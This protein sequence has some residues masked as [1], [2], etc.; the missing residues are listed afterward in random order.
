MPL[1]SLLQC[2]PS[3]VAGLTGWPWT[4]ET[5]TEI[6]ASRHDWPRISIVTPSYNQAA[7]LEETIRSVLLQNYPN[8]QYI[9]ID[10]GSTDGSREVIARYA[11]WLD[12]W[13]SERDRGQSHAI[14]KGLSRCN[15]TWFNWIN[16]D[17]CL[18]PGALAAVAAAHRP[19]ALLI[20]GFEVA[21]PT[22]ATSVPLGRTKTGPTV[23]DALVNHFICQQGMFFR[24]DAVKARHGVREDLHYVMDLELFADLLLQGG[25]EAVSVTSAHLAF[26]RR[27]VAAKTTLAPEKFFAEEHRL[28][29]GLGRAA[30]IDATLL[31]HL[32]AS[33]PIEIPKTATARI[34]P[35]RLA[36]LLAK[37]YWWDG[38]IETA[39]RQRQLGEFRREA[40]AFAQSFPQVT[41][42]RIS[43]LH[44]L[45]RLPEPLLRF[46]SQFR[47][48]PQP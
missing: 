16:S 32:H 28:F 36:R 27:H 47:A 10:G 39:W 22:L 25:P 15:G 18:L 26:F 5:P 23:E 4:E 38:T 2:L 48:E 17:D 43:M 31:G 11:P 8:L 20:S 29:A 33:E 41:N 1:N 13:E 14:N 3:P 37:K 19:D 21:G 34:E 12:H 45:A 24:T 42:R 35:T 7:F 46:V 40:R 30:G 44:F 6:Y 9:V